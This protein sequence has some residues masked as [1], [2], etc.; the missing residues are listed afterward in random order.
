[1]MPPNMQPVRSEVLVSPD[2]QNE[3]MPMLLCWLAG[4]GT[5]DGAIGEGPGRYSTPP[6]PTPRPL[7]GRPVH[8]SIVVD[9]LFLALFVIIMLDE[10]I[11]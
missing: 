10:L 3:Q 7:C 8:Y 1:M 6:T 11:K 5:V 4:H 2:G 9:A